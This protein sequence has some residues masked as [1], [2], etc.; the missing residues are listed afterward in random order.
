[1]LGDVV[2]AIANQAAAAAARENGGT[3]PAPEPKGPEGTPAEPGG[4]TVQLGSLPTQEEA[5]KMAV[6]N[7]G[8][9]LEGLKKT[10]EK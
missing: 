3:S 7:W 1:M 9:M 6:D 10:A 4:F 8:P 5:D 2:Q